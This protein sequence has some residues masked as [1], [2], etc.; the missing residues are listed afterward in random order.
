MSKNVIFVDNIGRT[1]VGAE[2]TKK[3]TKTQLAVDDPAIVFVQPNAES[4]QIQVQVIPL[5]FKE[6]MSEKNRDGHVT[7]HFHRSNLVTSSNL[8]V[9]EKLE[10]Q[11]ERVVTAGPET[12]PGIVVDKKAESKDPEVVKLFDDE[13]K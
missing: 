6:L 12:P 11:Y 10:T 7:W 2:N 3:S 8:E 13:E 4:G 9:D 5:F 1:I